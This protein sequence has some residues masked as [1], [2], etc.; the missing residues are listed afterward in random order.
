MK[1]KILAILFFQFLNLAY[2]Q[3]LTIKNL[4]VS[5]VY[6]NMNK[7]VLEL[8]EEDGKGPYVKLK[9]EFK[10]KSEER[11]KLSPSKARI[12]I[13][14]R[15][16]GEKYERVVTT[17]EL[18]EIYNI[19]LNP[20]ESFTYIVGEWLLYGT[21]LWVDKKMNYITET[22]KILPTLKISYLEKNC[23]KEFLSKSIKNIEL[24]DEDLIDL[25]E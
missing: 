8:S 12:K 15:V 21:D 3:E 25:N 23:K 2:S 5:H 7:E 17:H 18:Q 1:T 16:A 19:E 11:I 9:L 13:L 6:K 24:I 20:N 14:F 10:N 22:L 4:K